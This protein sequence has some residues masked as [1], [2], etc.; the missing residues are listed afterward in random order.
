M[1]IKKAS[2]MFTILLMCILIVFGLAACGKEEKIPEYVTTIGAEIADEL[3]SG[4]FYLDGDMYQFP[5]TVGDFLD[6]G[7]SVSANYTNADTFA[8]AP[9]GQTNSFALVKEVEDCYQDV[10]DV[11]CYV[12]NPTEEELPLEEC[13]IGKITINAP[14][15]MMFPGGIWEKTTH[16]KVISAYGEPKTFDND[17]DIFYTMLYDIVMEDG[18]KWEVE[19]MTNNFDICHVVYTW[20]GMEID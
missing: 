13:M 2:C 3:S 8:L 14:A 17:S 15:K 7:Y 4:Q 9:G 18:S 10:H 5:L 19:I 20:E 1:K 6:N 16:E 11:R 12:Y